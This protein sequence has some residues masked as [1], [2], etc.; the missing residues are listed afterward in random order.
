[1][2]ALFQNILTA[3]FHGSIVILAVLLL[4]VLLKRAPRKFICFLW[5]LAG[6]RLLMPF[7]IQSSLSLQPMPEVA[8]VQQWR[9]PDAPIPQ[10]TFPAAPAE[11]EAQPQEVQLP[12]TLDTPEAPEAPVSAAAAPVKTTAEPVK[13]KLNWKG[14]IPYVCLGITLCFGLYTIFA[15]LS[16]KYKVREATKIRG[17]WESDQ[18]ETAFILGFIRPQIYIPV[19]LSPTVRKHILAHERTHLEKGDHWFKMIGFLALALHWFNPLVWIAYILL[20]KDIELAC[21]ERVVQFMELEERKSY[22]AALLNCS[23]KHAHFAACPVAFGEVS[24]KDRIKTVLNYRRPS[25]WVSL[26]G[27]AA[28]VFVAVCLLTNPAKDNQDPAP[29]AE[30]LQEQADLTRCHD[31]L[32]ALLAQESCTLN[33]IGSNQ[34]FQWQAYLA[35]L[36]EDTL[37]EYVPSSSPDPISGRMEYG[38]KHYAYQSGV[39][40]ETE[41]KDTQFEGYLDFFRWELSEAALV[42]S[43]KNDSWEAICFTTTWR[44][45]SGTAQTAT[46]T[47]YF[48]AEGKLSSI[49]VQNAP[50]LD[51]EKIMLDTWS[52]SEGWTAEDCFNEAAAAIGGG[53][54]SAEDLAEQAVY[55]AWGFVFRVDDDRLSDSGSDV[56]YAQDEIGRG[57]LS[58]TDEYWLERKVGSSWEVVTPVNKPTWSSTTQGVA[59]GTST[60]GYIDWTP[61]YGKLSSGTYRMGK[62]VRCREDSTGYSAVHD[63]YAEF[64]ICSVVDTN[65]PEAA[66]AVERCY[67]ALEALKNKTSIHWLSV[68]GNTNYE[69][70]LD[71]DNVLNINHYGLWEVDPEYLTEHD[72]EI[73]PR[74]DTS[75]HYNGVAYGDIREDPE[76]LVSKVLGLGV[77]DLSPSLNNYRFEDDFN[78]LFFQRTNHQISFPE[79]VG[80]VSDEMVRFVTTWGVVGLEYDKCTAQLTYR[81]DED[82]NLTYMEYL[83]T[84]DEKPISYYIEVYDDTAEE[85]DAKIRSYTEDIYVSSFSWEAA[86]AKYATDEFNHRDSGFVNSSSAPITGPVEAARR[87]L[88][89]Y[90]KLGSYLNL[91]I[92]HDDGAGMW[93]V[94]VRSY[95]D[96]QATYEYRDIYLD[97]NG[98]TQLLVYEGPIGYDEARK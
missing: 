69:Y 1:M 51:T 12:Q 71:G 83:P 80:V 39:W 88:L 5:M 14:M 50:N 79:G 48:D 47:Y 13:A 78:Y 40:V 44:E 18:I 15:Y 11:Q 65:S 43:T 95:H 91:D 37:W 54:V 23:A 32:D 45:D 19:G 3:S 85:I 64:E 82:G 41:E 8:Q 59:K 34:Y 87:A 55:D 7:E 72:Y 42:S 49:E 96:Y 36:G 97:D 60:F 24:V 2:N 26:L 20:C 35:R 89:E 21:D 53:T 28:I 93:R 22:S 57:V 31:A 94:T 86:K 62:T 17:G 16:L 30:A 6:L 98:V 70:W 46:H 4:R 38:G 33:L 27:V 58:T 81:F 63:F 61:I 76:V 92:A 68:M 73:A 29:T 84:Y 25:F 10:E 77:T 75:V 9:S 56:Y 90:P 66:A 52:R 67:S 74:T